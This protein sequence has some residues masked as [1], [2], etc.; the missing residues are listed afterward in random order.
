MAD[1]RLKEAANLAKSKICDSLSLIERKFNMNFD[2]KITEN[3]K[4][5]VFSSVKNYDLKFYQT[6]GKI[7][8]KPVHDEFIVK[9]NDF[10]LALPNALQS[11]FIII[12]ND[13]FDIISIKFT[14]Y[15]KLPFGL[16]KIIVLFDDQLE[17]DNIEYYSTS[18]NS[19]NKSKCL[20]NS[21]TDE[22]LLFILFNNTTDVVKE[23]LPEYHIPSAYDFSSQD[24]ADRL[25][26]F[27]MLTL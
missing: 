21:F 25:N 8:F 13:N 18:G 27:S 2:F 22:V 4:N 11:F 5:I 17:L 20:L 9:V 14:S 26:V 1:N 6:H 15:K 12:F 3:A 23:L 19:F 16:S 10:K 24:F 7:I